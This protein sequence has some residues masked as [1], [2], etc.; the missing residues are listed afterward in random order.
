MAMVM[1]MVMMITM[2]MDCDYDYRR[3]VTL[4]HHNTPTQQCTRT[5]GSASRSCTRPAKTPT[6]T[7]A[8]ASA[9]VPVRYIDGMSC[10]IHRSSLHPSFHRHSLPRH[11][12]TVQSVEKILLSVVSML[13]EPNDESPANIEAAVCRWFPLTNVSSHFALAEWMIQ[14]IWRSDRQHFNRIVEDTVRRSLGL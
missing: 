5:A 14:K 10:L 8:A 13:A 2:M 3:R 4:D 11:S 7:R 9:G 1:V 6:C 12:L